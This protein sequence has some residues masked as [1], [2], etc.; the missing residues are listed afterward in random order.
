MWRKVMKWQK[1]KENVKFLKADFKITDMIAGVFTFAILGVF[2]LYFHNDY[3]DLV[4]VKYRFYYISVFVTAILIIW[5]SLSFRLRGLNIKKH[6]K[7]LS[8]TDKAML[9]F[10]LVF[11]VSTLFSNYKYEAFWGNEGTWVGLF[12]ISVFFISYICMSRNLK[13]RSWYL[14][15][16]LVSGMLVCFLGIANFFYFDP[17]HMKV[18]LNEAQKNHFVSTFG[19][20]NQYTSYVALVMAVSTTLF[21]TSEKWYSSIWYYLC[22][23]VSFAAIILGISDN[24]YLSTFVLFALLPLYLFSKRNWS[25]RYIVVLATYVSVMAVIELFLSNYQGETLPLISLFSTLVASGF[26]ALTAVILWLIAAVW[27]IWDF[28]KKHSGGNVRVKNNPTVQCLWGGF[29]IVCGFIVIG[30]LIDINMGGKSERY[31]AISNY[32]LLTDSWGNYRGWAWKTGLK[33]FHKFSLFEKLFGYGPETFYILMVTRFWE[34]MTTVTGLKFMSAHNQLIQYLVT[35]GILG[36]T[37]Y[38]WLLFTLIKQMVRYS[39]RNKVWVMP[40]VFALLCYN[41]QNMVNFDTIL[42]TPIYWTL[43]YLGLTGSFDCDI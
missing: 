19:N 23:V 9:L 13:F 11:L 22:M 37:S 41:A 27:Y 24:G 2:P 6:K 36:L 18:Y 29:L 31:G 30:V 33:V 7:K 35:T 21:S 8:R 42:V 43:I 4:D 12:L 20:I 1:L 25:K 10:W 14:E 32:L 28:N 17:L 39:G 3:L 26:S 38:I 40:I 15:I 34:E 5:I 16:F